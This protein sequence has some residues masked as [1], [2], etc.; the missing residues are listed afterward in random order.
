MGYFK[1]SVTLTN[2]EI[3]FIKLAS[4]AFI[5]LVAKW[6]QAEYNWDMLKELDYWLLIVIILVFAYLP[7]KKF[8]RK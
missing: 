5:V 2:M 4:M 8:F 6:L 7:A 3:G 1:K